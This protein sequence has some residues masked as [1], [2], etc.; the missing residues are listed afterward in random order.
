MDHSRSLVIPQHQLLTLSETNDS[1][2]EEGKG[3][4]QN[5]VGMK[6]KREDKEKEAEN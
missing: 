4:R 2:Q 6:E 5:T 3:V 1:F